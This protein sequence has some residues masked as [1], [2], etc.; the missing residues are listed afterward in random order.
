M[1]LLKHFVICFKFAVGRSHPKKGRT[2]EAATDDTR[3]VPE[4]DFGLGKRRRFASGMK[5]S[6][7]FFPILHKSSF[8]GPIHI[9]RF[10]YIK[11][12]NVFFKFE[13]FLKLFLFFKG[14]SFLPIE[15]PIYRL[16]YCATEFE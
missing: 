6:P 11:F 15:E 10:I 12:L 14:S 8:Y 9:C 5:F 13:P 16:S 7:L 2:T 4:E 1:I 3:A